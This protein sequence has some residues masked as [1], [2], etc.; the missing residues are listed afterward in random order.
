MTTYE[1]FDQSENL[2]IGH[3]SSEKCPIPIMFPSEVLVSIGI[4]AS[5]GAGVTGSNLVPC[6]PTG[7]APVVDCD[8]VDALLVVNSDL[9]DTTC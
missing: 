6:P 9:A 5:L 4:M 7:A 2:Q 1:L 3:S 8:S